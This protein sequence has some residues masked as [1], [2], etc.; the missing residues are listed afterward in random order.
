[1]GFDFKDVDQNQR[2]TDTIG[3]G[4]T[5]L[6]PRA[7]KYLFQLTESAILLQ[8]VKEQRAYLYLYGWVTY[9]RHF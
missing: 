1:V 6:G 4:P 5:L 9:R 7:K 8:A 3:E 2:V